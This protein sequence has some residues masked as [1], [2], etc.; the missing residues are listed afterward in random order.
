LFRKV[1][2]AS[3]SIPVAFPPVFFE[4]ELTPG[5]PRHDEMHVDGGVGARVFLNGGVFRGSA[6]RERGGHGGTG[7]EDIFVVHNGQLLAE[8]EP[9]SRSLAQIATRS[10]DALGRTAVLGDLLRIHA[11]AQREG[12]SF[13]WVTI[14]RDVSMV[15]EEVFDPVHMQALYDLGLQM[16]E[17][18]DAWRTQPPGQQP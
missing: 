18:N 16:A 3:A 9:V 7:R 11:H 8:P 17:S 1:M 4:V 10:I 2:L 15:A 14:P 6:I 5:G 12:G 13:R